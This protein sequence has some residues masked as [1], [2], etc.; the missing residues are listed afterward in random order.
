MGRDYL[1]EEYDQLVD[2]MIATCSADFFARVDGFGIESDRPIFIVGLPRSGTTL[3][4]Q[5]LAA[6]SKV[7][8]AGELHLAQ[9]VFET[10]PTVLGLELPPLRCLEEITREAADWL[11]RKHL[12][13]LDE[14][15]PGTCLVA[16]KM[17]ENYFFLG[18]LALLF[19]RA[20][21]IHCRR[22]LRDVAVSCWFTNFREVRWAH[23]LDHI[24][25]KF[26]AYRRLMHHWSRTLP[27]PVLEVDYEQTVA[28]LDGTAR[29]LIAW[30][31]LDW[32]PECLDFH[33]PRN[34]VKTASVSQI[35]QPIYSRSVGRWR[36]YESELGSLFDRL[37]PLI[38]EESRESNTISATV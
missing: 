9:S 16:D 32:E 1:P 34:P 10:L 33:K 14:I 22:D 35:R 37:E 36:N 23:H 28:D 24:A 6:H 25:A 17:P 29:R 8:G 27:V 38:P 19:P 12:G 31:D 13:G 30:C 21:F 15:A 5:I 18:L 4:E 20:K 26:A 11:A 3:T 2:E 7:H